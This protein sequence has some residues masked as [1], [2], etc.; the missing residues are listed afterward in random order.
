MQTTSVLEAFP[1]PGIFS[2]SP[3]AVL[4]EELPRGV[5]STFSQTDWIAQ[6]LY[7][8][9]EVYVVP[10][11]VKVFRFLR[12]HPS[13]IEVVWEAAHMLRHIFG[14]DARLLLDL[15]RDP[16]VGYEELFAFVHVEGPAEEVFEKLRAFDEEWFLDR[17]EEIHGLFNVNVVFA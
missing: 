1:S 13:L 8:I 9:R 16:E 4:G 2:G 12:Q 14:P 6:V 10:H 7:G 3:T 17:Q 5:S 15:V 11:P